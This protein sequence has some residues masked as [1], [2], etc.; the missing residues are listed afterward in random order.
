[1]NFF[2]F[3]TG[4]NKKKIASAIVLFLILAMIIMFLPGR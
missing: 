4:K 2:K 1:M 3:F